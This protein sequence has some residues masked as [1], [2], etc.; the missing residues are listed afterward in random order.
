MKRLFTPILVLCVIAVTSIAPTANVQARGLIPS[1]PELSA[2]AWLLVDATTGEVLIEHNAD[3]QLPPASLTKM[4][5]SYIASDEMSKGR[6]QPDEMVNVSEKAWRMGG[7][8][9]FIK[10]GNQVAV[11]D[12]LRGII[13]QSGNDASVAMAEHIAGAEDAF[14]DLMNQQ[15]QLL[16]MNDSHF[17]NSTGWPAEGHLTTA[18]DL[19][20][21]ARAII[22]DF[23]EHYALYKEKYF[24]YN[25]IR[26]PNRNRL[27]WS[28]KAIDGLKTGH[29]E[30]AGY[31][32]VSSGVKNG[33]RLIAVVMGTDSEKSRAR[34]SQK[35]LSYGFRY[36][37]TESIYQKNEELKSVRVWKGQS[38]Q[39]SLVVGDDVIMT[40]PRDARQALDLELELPTTFEAP[41]AAGQEMGVVR[42]SLDGKTLKKVP[43]VAAEAVEEAGF[44]ARFIDSIKMFFAELM[45]G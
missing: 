25:N 23:P 45:G 44:F 14:A 26:Q 31:C 18:K 38:E 10:E 24:T 3:E 34:E 19:G 1:P 12:L 42:I 7:S 22:N 36:Y 16:G 37:R 2:T 21:L 40:L 32:L 20:L 11:K 5:T 27:L 9:M 33:I 39:L 41:I 43:V 4:M 30:A 6:M 15:A 29:T 8:K 17:E 28:D 35:L 13:I